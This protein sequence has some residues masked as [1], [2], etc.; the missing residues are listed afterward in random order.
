M[1]PIEPVHANEAGLQRPLAT[2]RGMLSC[3][4]GAAA[5]L[6]LTACGGA[7]DGD[8]TPAR[9]TSRARDVEIVNYALT[10]EYLEAQLYDRAVDSGFFSGE[11]LDLVKRFRAHE[12]QHI[13]ALTAA[14]GKLG[15][16]PVGEPEGEF[17]AD[18][19]IAFLKL[20]QRLENLGAAAYLGQA[21]RIDD[22]EILAAVLSIHS[23]EARHA[24]VLS[25]ILEKDIAPTGA[26]A[27]PATM[28]EV[29]PVANLFMSK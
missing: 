16:T 21:H 7:D 28:T 4:G 14:V 18:D 27:K 20:A 24:A 1:A 23:V 13:D 2:R 5:G 6:V 26:F 15:G 10:L 12:R 9:G 11:E 19:R 8:R 22:D 3:A 25:S 17:D 29:L